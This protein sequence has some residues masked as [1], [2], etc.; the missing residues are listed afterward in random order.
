MFILL[1]VILAYSLYLEFQICEQGRR[2]TTKLDHSPGKK[3][4]L[5]GGSNCQAVSQGQRRRK[6]QKQKTLASIRGTGSIV[7]G[8]WGRGRLSQNSR[9]PHGDFD[10]LQ[11]CLLE[12]T[13]CR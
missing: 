6:K 2:E 10:L 11:A 4:G 7:G 3:K 12:V 5:L 9:E 8:R 1:F 13:G